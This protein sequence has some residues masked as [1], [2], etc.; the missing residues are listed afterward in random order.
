MNVA[1]RITELIADEFG[2]SV[3]NI[4]DET[5][6]IEDIKADSLDVMEFI[7]TVEDEFGITV[8][9][10]LIPTLTTVGVAINYVKSQIA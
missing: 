3:D 6:F 5:R 8:D 10:D 2:L 7:M 4:H 9:D 1:Q